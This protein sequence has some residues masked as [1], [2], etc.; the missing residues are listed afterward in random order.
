M[1][2]KVVRPNHRSPEKLKSVSGILFL[3]F[4]GALAHLFV[5]ISDAR[6]ACEILLCRTLEFELQNKGYR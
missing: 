1:V 4:Q 3:S 2:K 5:G 6:N